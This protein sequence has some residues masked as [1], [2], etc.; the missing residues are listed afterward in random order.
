MKKLSTLALA[1][2]M[3]GGIAFLTGCGE[4]SEADK[5]ADAVEDAGEK[6]ADAIKDATN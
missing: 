1:A 5:A 4:K 6:A 2:L 3:F